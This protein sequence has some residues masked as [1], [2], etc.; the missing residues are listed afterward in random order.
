MTDP[1]IR[2]LVV[3]HHQTF[4]ELLGFALGGQPD[5]RYVGHANT[6]AEALRLV[7]E[8]RPDVVL[9]DVELPD[10]DG[11]VTT[12]LLRAGHPETRVV[13]LTAS[14]E[15]ALVGRAAAAGASGFLTKNGA[16]GDILHAVHTAHGG[17]MTVSSHLLTGLLKSTAPGTDPAGGPSGGLTA[18]E[19]EVLRLMGTGLDARAIARRLGIS[20]HTCR[21]YVKSVLAKLEAHSQLEAVAV[22]TRRGLLTSG[23]GTDR[24]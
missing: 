23:P 16:L 22:A 12:E 24:R 2:V 20:V 8:L 6:G 18:R 21:G 1:P 17:G 9:M 5:L 10:A 3:D 14:T 13:V 11:I 15:P 19:H 4:A 7:E